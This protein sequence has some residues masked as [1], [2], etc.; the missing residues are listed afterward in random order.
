MSLWSSRTCAGQTQTDNKVQFCSVFCVWLS[1]KWGHDPV[2]V[3]GASASRPSEEINIIIMFLTSSK[4]ST[5]CSRLFPFNSSF[6]MLPPFDLA[7]LLCCINEVN[8]FLKWEV[9]SELTTSCLLAG[10]LWPGMGVYICRYYYVWLLSYSRS[11][12][13]QQSRQSRLFSL[14]PHVQTEPTKRR[15]DFTEWIQEAKGPYSIMSN[16]QTTVRENRQFREMTRT[17]WECF[18]R[19]LEADGHG[20]RQESLAAFVISTCQPDEVVSWIR[21]CF[22]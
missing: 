5:N 22:V 12:K 21:L 19:T 6:I 18:Q 15:G 8:A 4:L 2:R 3:T 16:R 10:M 1:F 20:W 7:M 11:L 13:S 14:G 17:F 9:G